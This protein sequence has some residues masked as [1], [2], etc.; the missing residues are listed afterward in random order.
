MTGDVGDGPAWRP[1]GPRPGGGI[2]DDSSEGISCS[3][4][5]VLLLLRSAIRSRLICQSIYVAGYRN[6][7]LPSGTWHVGMA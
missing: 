2:V 1:A 5:L 4:I 3:V 7:P 6:G